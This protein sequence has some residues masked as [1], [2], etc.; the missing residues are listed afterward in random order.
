MGDLLL[1]ISAVLEKV[2]KLKSQ[3]VATSIIFVL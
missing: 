1:S 3:N 2:Q